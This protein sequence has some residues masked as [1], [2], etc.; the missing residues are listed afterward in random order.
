MQA[1]M[2]IVL[3]TALAFVPLAAAA[4][5]P[6]F[7]AELPRI[8]PVS[9]ERALATF[10][11]QPG[12]RLELVAAEPLVASPVAVCWDAR[13]RLYVAE[14]RGYSEHR[15]EK[16]SRIRILFD[17]DNDGRYD[18]AKVFADELLWPTAIIAADDGVYVGDA[19][20]ILFLKDTNGDDVADERRRVYT[21]FGVHNV[22]GLLNTFLWGLDNRIHGSASSCGGD[23]RRVGVEGDPLRVNG[24]DFSFDA[25]G[26]R[27]ESGGAQHGM[28]FDDFGH[29]FVCSNSDH[30]QQVMYDDRNLRSRRVGP[31]PSRVSIATDGPQAE[32][33]RISPVEP[34]RIVRTRLRVTGAVPGIIE[35]GGRA[36][37]YFT[38]ASGIT[39]VRGGAFVN[40]ALYG[41]AVVGDVG[42]N[43]VHRKKLSR[44]GLRFRADRID[45]QS[46]LVASK[47]NWFRPAQFANGPDGG[48]YILD[49]Y[50][51]V[52]EHPASLPPMIKKHLDLDSGRD[53]GRIYRLV[54]EAWQRKP[55]AWPADVSGD[56][57]VKLLSD[58]NAWTRETAARLLCERGGDKAVPKLR[59]LALRGDS[60]LATLHAM[61]SLRTLENLDESIVARNLKNANHAVRVHALRLAE[62][63]L[64]ESTGLQKQVLACAD[65]PSIEVRYQAAFT[66]GLIESPEKR[67]A[68]VRLLD[69]HG[70]D[71]Y[72]RFACLQSLEGDAATLLLDLLKEPT[73][74]D[75]VDTLVALARIVG[76]EGKAEQ[77]EATLHAIAARDEPSLIELSPVVQQLVS[78]KKP[79]ADWYE[80]W[81]AKTLAAAQKNAFDDSQPL[82]R[83][84][85]AIRALWCATFSEADDALAQ[86]LTPAQPPALQHA[87][88]D[89]LALFSD[90]AAADLLLR[91]WPQLG[92]ET[93]RRALDVLVSRPAWCEAL[94]ASVERGDV[95]IS[96]IDPV[97]VT[98][99]QNH[100]NKEI[101]DIAKR[102]WSASSRR[103]DIV[104]QYRPVLQQSGDAALGKAVFAKQCAQCHRLE[105]VGIE[106]G[107][108][109]AAMKARGAEA[110]VL[111]VLDPNREV[112]PQYIAYA[113]NTIDGRTTTG[114]IASESAAGIVLRQ[115][116]GKQIELSRTEIEAIRSTGLSLMPEG[117]EKQIDAKAMADL[118]AYLLSLKG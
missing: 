118:L 13:G 24:R 112:N 56:E 67:A 104:E 85:A 74:G 58:A 70:G 7:T 29:K 109:L 100:P 60:P 30:C 96:E 43:L 21:G 91:Q 89:T 28:S 99:L 44:D 63:F 81:R 59:E 101:G 42:S 52:I 53:R 6:D 3:L 27:A 111:N 12:Y 19:P 114:L 95:R 88:C 8:E 18:R 84:L 40:D 14:M 23:I 80:R 38:G 57:L 76:R 47:D 82:P 5:E 105:G 41:K 69:A 72:F 17:D 54:P 36:A 71:P 45:E 106:V 31:P 2:R 26:I 90:G 22:Q 34:W 87:A 16:L 113:V 73:A 11:V 92:P 94:V 108:N 97:H 51:E 86:A 46:E 20:D 110:I 4:D 64:A 75:K 37:G 10:K 83:R 39:I 25:R 65:D 107:P 48:L 116:D 102:L 62:P 50:R 68:L 66:L 55:V 61:Y 93:R 79:T 117:L 32:V 103:A 15:D 33:F 35:G 77:I 78:G 98:A 115:A 1:V 9:P 49:V